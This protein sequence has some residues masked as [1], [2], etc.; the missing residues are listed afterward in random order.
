MTFS[1]LLMLKFKKKSLFSK[2]KWEEGGQQNKLLQ[3]LKEKVTAAVCR[4]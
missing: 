2:G 1:R 4:G 3:M